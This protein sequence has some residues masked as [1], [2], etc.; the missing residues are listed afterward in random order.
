MA[1]IS[2]CWYWAHCAYPLQL[3]LWLVALGA[4]RV[5]MARNGFVVIL[6]VHEVF[7]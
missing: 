6:D 1:A 7:P 5:Q 3:A 2:N 4:I